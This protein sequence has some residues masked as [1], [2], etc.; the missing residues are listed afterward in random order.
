[1]KHVT[2]EIMFDDL[3]PEVQAEVLKALHIEDASDYNFDVVPMAVYE[4]DVCEC[5]QGGDESDYCADCPY[6]A[7]YRYDEKTGDCVRRE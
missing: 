1:M 6:A 5:P 4:T 2:L 3:K 7:D